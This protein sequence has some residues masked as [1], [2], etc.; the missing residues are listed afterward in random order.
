MSERDLLPGEYAVLGLLL[1]GPRH[2]YEIARCFV[3]ADLTSVC[4]VE[5]SALYSYLRNVEVRALVEWTEE[6]VGAR[7]PRKVYSLTP[8][9]ADVLHEWLRAPVN[10]IREVRLAF[11]LKLYFLHRLDPTAERELVA[12]QVD[13]C[14]QYL[15]RLPGG[16]DLHGFQLAVVGSKRSAAEAT[17]S[18]LKSYASELEQKIAR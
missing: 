10:R 15:E 17:L 16:E 12:S 4:T 5:Q 18:W 8:A 2:G 11:L 7:P 1:D 9:G 14:E 3:D 6:R 13:A